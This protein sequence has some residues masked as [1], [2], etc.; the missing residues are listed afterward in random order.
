MNN[1][2]LQQELHYLI[3]LLKEHLRAVPQAHDPDRNFDGQFIRFTRTQFLPAKTEHD[4]ES[5]WGMFES[6]GIELASKA[7][8]WTYAYLIPDETMRRYYAS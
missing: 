6:H 8:G 4:W 2:N 3:P 7:D 5:L 1:K